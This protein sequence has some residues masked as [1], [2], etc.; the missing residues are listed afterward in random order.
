[1]ADDDRLSL[2][3][4]VL[5]VLVILAFVVLVVIWFRMGLL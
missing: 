5:A 1:M 3:E 2:V 4:K